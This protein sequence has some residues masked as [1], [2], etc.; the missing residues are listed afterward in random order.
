MNPTPIPNEITASA[1]L[2]GIST[3]VAGWGVTYLVKSVLRNNIETPTG[4]MDKVKLF[5][6]T[7]VAVGIATQASNNYV[8][9][10]I[11][12][13][14]ESIRKIQATLNGDTNGGSTATGEQPAAQ[15][16]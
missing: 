16:A 13:G 9:G 4:K 6:G 14:I 15:G 8:E 3:A 2:K 5:I 11:D 7:A 10:K 12:R 1:V